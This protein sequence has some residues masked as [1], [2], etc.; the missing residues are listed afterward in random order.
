MAIKQ[1]AIHEA[2]TVCRVP[3]YSSKIQAGFPSPADDYM[4]RK[5]DLNELLIKHPAAT[6]Y[7]QVNGDSMT[8]VGIYDGDILVV[9]RAVKPVHGDVV[10]AVVDGEFACKILDTHKQQLLSANITYPPI[11]I[12]EGTDFMVEGVVTS[13]IRRHRCLPL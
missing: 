10:V 1:I 9:D 6:Y 4:D 13:S 3:F 5:L 12:R 2:A 11:A 8:G 7:C